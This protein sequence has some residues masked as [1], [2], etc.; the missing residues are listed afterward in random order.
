MEV[1]RV[2]ALGIPGLYVTGKRPLAEDEAAKLGGAWLGWAKSLSQA[3]QTPVMK[4]NRHPMEATL[5]DKIHSNC[6]SS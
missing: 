5:H 6:Q 1:T 2:S 4:Y 3:G